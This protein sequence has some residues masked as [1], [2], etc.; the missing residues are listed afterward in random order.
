MPFSPFISY[1]SIFI[2][3]MVNKDNHRDIRQE[4]H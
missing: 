1:D 3:I 4:V 2:F